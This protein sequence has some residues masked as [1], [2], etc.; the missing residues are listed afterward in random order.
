MRNQQTCP[1]PQ[2]LS[3]NAIMLTVDGVA[4]MLACSPRTVYRLSDRG[5]IPPPVRLGGLVR[6]PNATIEKWVAEG[7]PAQS[8]ARK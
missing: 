7:C 5:R 3:D 8:R 6:W 2:S 4:A 1:Q